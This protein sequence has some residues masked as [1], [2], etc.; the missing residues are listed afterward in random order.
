MYGKLNLIVLIMGQ[1]LSL[2]RERQLLARG[3][4][5]LKS[6]KRGFGM[7]EL[8]G[9]A[10]TLIIAAFVIIPGLK[11]FAKLLMA[12]LNTWWTGTIFKD[13][14]PTSAA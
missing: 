10:A 13:I 8:L 11:D 9:I 12:N 6:D 1:V 2:R 4:D 5:R 7:N 14:F 3:V